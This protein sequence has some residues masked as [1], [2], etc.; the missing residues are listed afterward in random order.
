MTVC[1]IAIR[2]KSRVAISLL[3][4]PPPNIEGAEYEGEK[5]LIDKTIS[6]RCNITKNAEL[7]L[8]D[9]KQLVYVS[10]CYRAKQR[11]IWLLS[12]QDYSEKGLF[13][14][15]TKNFT[16]KASAFAVSQMVERRFIND[17]LINLFIRQSIPD[18]NMATLISLVEMFLML[19][20]SFLSRIKEV[21]T[22]RAIGLKKKDIYRMFTGEILVI[23]FITAIP[24]IAIMYFALTQMVTI[25]YYIEGLYIITP[26]IAVITFAI[27]LVFNL[28]AGLIPVF[29]TMRKTPAQIL[30][31]T[32]I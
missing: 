18:L 9:I 25:T 8:E 30:A 5:L 21:G 28:I 31:R 14:K 16:P 17:L 20:S 26:M 4:P 2:R 12:G 29:S 23:T 13:E 32:D 11:A 6:A 15:L 1:E 19:R 27:I 24:G 22:L 7:S 3:P 10:E